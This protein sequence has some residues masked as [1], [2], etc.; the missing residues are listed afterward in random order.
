MEK[1]QLIP[2]MSYVCPKC[3]KEH[4]VI[5]QGAELTDNQR[6]EVEYVCGIPDS[7]THQDEGDLEH[8]KIL[9]KIISVAPYKVR[10][11]F[12]KTWYLTEIYGKKPQVVKI[13][14]LASADYDEDDED[15]E[16]GDD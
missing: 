6:I 7:T 3:E 2:C 9:F 12:C 8:F 5:P 11:E 16:E 15:D 13:D 10:C 4:V 1:V 14:P